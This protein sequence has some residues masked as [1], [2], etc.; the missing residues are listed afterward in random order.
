MIEVPDFSR[1]PRAVEPSG[2]PSVELAQ[3]VQR[4]IDALR[5]LQE[6][7]ADHEQRITAL[8]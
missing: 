6:T 8:E 1:L 7:I 5:E 2:Q 3:Q 4:L